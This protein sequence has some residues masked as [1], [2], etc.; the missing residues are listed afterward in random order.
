MN[1]PNNMVATLPV[2][3]DGALESGANV[4]TKTNFVEYEDGEK[5]T[6]LSFDIVA[7]LYLLINI[8]YILEV[9]LTTKRREQVIT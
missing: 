9:I 6:T 4:P 8:V 5:F 1:N 7:G 3:S 2:T